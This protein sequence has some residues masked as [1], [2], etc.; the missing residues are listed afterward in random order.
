MNS[1]DS[2]KSLF[3]FFNFVEILF[4]IGALTEDQAGCYRQRGVFHRKKIPGEFSYTGACYEPGC[5]LFPPPP[6][7]LEVIIR[8][9]AEP[10]WNY[11]TMPDGSG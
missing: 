10:V 9:N 3:S 5:T 6:R 4:F 8:K 7:I 11:S 2:P 1:A